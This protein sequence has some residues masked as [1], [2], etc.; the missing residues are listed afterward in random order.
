MLEEDYAGQPVVFIGV[1]SAKFENENDVNNI[2][3]AVERYEITHPVIVDKD[4]H[5]WNAYRVTAWPTIVIIGPDGK[6]AYKRSGEGQLQDIDVMITALLKRRDIAAEKI[7]ITSSPKETKRVLSFPGKIDY[8]DGILAIAD[9]NHNRIL[10][11]ELHGTK[12]KVL[13]EIGSIAGGLMDGSFANAMFSRPQGVAIADDRIYVADTENHAIRLIDLK[14]KTVETIAGTGE[15]SKGE[16]HKGKLNSPWDVLFRNN[17]LYIAMAGSH[18][19][20]EMDTR[21]RQLVSY[22]GTSAENI[23]DGPR[24]SAFL[25]QPS[26]LATD[27]EFL[28]FV[29]SEVSALRRVHFSSGVVETL[30]GK[31]LF[32]FGFADGQFDKALLQHPLGVDYSN[33]KVY[34]ADTYNHAIR[35]ADLRTRTVSALIG[36]KTSKICTIGDTECD[37]LPLY[38]PNDVISLGDALLIADTNNHLI[39][40]FKDGKLSDIEIVF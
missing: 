14:R 9:S 24:H 18:Q 33:G 19:I 5:I 17:K 36:R 23:I 4:H 21:T 29:D 10:V 39:R 30:I 20:W 13:Y 15:Q 8:K 26:G 3:S 22:A 40:L 31:G 1:H 32:V 37:Y 28:Y 11:T 12:A 35:E 2:Q 7:S 27:G 6:I 34:I 16:P 25:A 38:E